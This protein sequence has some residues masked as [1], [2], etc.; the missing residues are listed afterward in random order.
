MTSRGGP[1]HISA[2]IDDV[3]ADIWNRMR[4]HREQTGEPMPP[5]ANCSR[6]QP[7]KFATDSPRVRHECAKGA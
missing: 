6:E 1:V 7:A 2:V 3:L 5:F 4:A